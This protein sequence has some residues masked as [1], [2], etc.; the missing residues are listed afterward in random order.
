VGK[1]TSI[2]HDFISIALKLK[3]N[4]IEIMIGNVII[5]SRI[6]II[7]IEIQRGYATLNNFEHV[8]LF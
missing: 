3:K 5:E 4:Y 6:S 1:I 2:F 7:N 8:R